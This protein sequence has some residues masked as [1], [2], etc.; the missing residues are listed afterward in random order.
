MSCP[1]VSSSSPVIFYIGDILN[2]ESIVRINC[3]P[4]KPNI[5]S[6][7]TISFTPTIPNTLS[8]HKKP[9]S[10]SIHRTSN[11]NFRWLE[12]LSIF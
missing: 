2:D 3:K 12:L 6:M 11:N 5:P 7:P 10:I 8:T 4:N 1:N 9:A